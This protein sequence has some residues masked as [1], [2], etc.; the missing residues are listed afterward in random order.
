MPGVTLSTSQNHT[1]ETHMQQL[2]RSV[3]SRQPQSP[4]FLE[5]ILN[6]LCCCCPPRTADRRESLLRVVVIG[7]ASNARRKMP[8]P[9]RR[10]SEEASNPKVEFLY[11]AMKEWDYTQVRKII[12]DTELTADKRIEILSCLNAMQTHHLFFDPAYLAEQV[13]ISPNLFNQIKSFASLATVCKNSQ[14]LRQTE[15][16]DKNTIMHVLDIQYVQMS[17]IILKDISPPPQPQFECVLWGV[18]YNFDEEHMPDAVRQLMVDYYL[19]EKEPISRN[20]DERGS[21]FTSMSTQA[22][23]IV[24]NDADT[25]RE[26]L[27]P[28]IRQLDKII[29]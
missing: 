7:T 13:E 29:S 24:S 28:E 25:S 11:D 17:K 18:F 5:K 14:T 10:A 19:D 15:R 3:P 9:S 22:H 4:T 23:S 27:S 21:A 16:L 26:D 6:I 1:Q 2:T 12:S 8:S 20:S